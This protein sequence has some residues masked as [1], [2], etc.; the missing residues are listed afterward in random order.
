MTLYRRVYAWITDYSEQTVPDSISEE[1]YRE[2]PRNFV[3]NLL[4]GTSTKLAEQLASPDLVLVWLLSALGAPVFFAGMLE[5]IR[6]GAASFPQLVVSGRM[7]AYAKRKWFWVG[8]GLVQAIALLIMLATALSLT[9]VW[10]GVVIV[11]ALLGFSVASGVGSVAFKDVLGKTIPENKRGQLLGL[12]SSTGGG[13]TIAA[14]LVLYGVVSGTSQIWVFVVLLGVAAALWALAAALFW[15]IQEQPGETEEEEDTLSEARSGVELFREVPGFRQFIVSR[16][17]LL[18]AELSVPYYALRAHQL[19]GVGEGF[20]LFIVALG[21]A[22]LT[23]SPIWGRISDRVSNRIVMALGG[24]VG[25]VAAALALS[26]GFF[27]TSATSPLLFAFVFLVVGLARAG[28]R[29]GRKSYIVNAAPDDER[30]LYT[31]AANTIAGVLIFVFIGF[32]AV[33]QVVGIDATLATLL[34]FCLLGAA[35]AWRMPE[36][37]RMARSERDASASG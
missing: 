14:G 25:A 5:P 8:A 6:R 26:F 10:A 2:T 7:R 9:G 15:L 16:G 36:A 4:N 11:L 23:G 24:V 32:G 37:G 31:A 17:L 35:S 27:P 22:A 13:L 19:T 18:S 20:G 1:A 29:V 34:V 33:A 12:R 28:V 21:V 3:L 30:P